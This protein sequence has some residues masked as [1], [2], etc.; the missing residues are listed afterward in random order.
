MKG[1]LHID[2]KRIPVFN[3]EF[4]PIRD[5]RFDQSYRKYCEGLK[6]GRTKQKME[7]SGTMEV[8]WEASPIPATAWKKYNGSENYKGL[9]DV[10]SK[11]GDV[12]KRCRVVRWY[13]TIVGFEYEDSECSHLL[14]D[15]D[16]LMIR[17]S[18]INFFDYFQEKY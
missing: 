1:E 7:I 17:E 9:V 6:S 14:G 10:W 2:G 18:E 11:W 13:G 4:T 16:V 5:L 12:F 3:L 15:W 8:T